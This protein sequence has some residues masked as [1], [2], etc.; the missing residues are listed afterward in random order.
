MFVCYYAHILLDSGL[1]R[2]FSDSV[3]VIKA[4]TLESGRP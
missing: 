4:W 3:D 1:E 2:M